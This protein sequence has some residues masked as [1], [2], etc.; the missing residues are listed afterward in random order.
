MHHGDV[1]R[2]SSGK[3]PAAEEDGT[4]QVDILER[5]RICLVDEA[6]ERLECVLQAL[7]MI[8]GAVPVKQLPEDRASVTSRSATSVEI[9]ACALSLFAC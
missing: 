5:D 3:L 7:A 2:I 9:A 1:Y 6:G 8:D 4:G